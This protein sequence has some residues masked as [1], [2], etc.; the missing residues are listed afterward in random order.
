MSNSVATVR[1]CNGRRR[2]K[3]KRAAPPVRLSM[4]DLPHVCVMP[5]AGDLEDL[6][7]GQHEVLRAAAKQ[8]G[9]RREKAPEA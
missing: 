4:T 8:R 5:C 1:G 9:W 3:G 6:A 7:M 2:A